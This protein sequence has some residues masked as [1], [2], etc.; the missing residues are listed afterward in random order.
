MDEALT[1][2]TGATQQEIAMPKLKSFAKRTDYYFYSKGRIYN[3]IN[4]R[5][6]LHL[7]SKKI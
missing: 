6:H 1:L 7:I 5:D 4:Y 3:V 2:F